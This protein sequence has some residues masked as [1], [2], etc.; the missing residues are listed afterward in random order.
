[1]KRGIAYILSGTAYLAGIGLTL[2]SA[3]LITMASAQPPLL[4][5][6][7]AI[8]GV[9]FFGITRSVARYF[10]RLTSHRTVF[11]KLSAL[12]VHLFESLN[13]NSFALVRDVGEG[14]LVKRIVD[15]V[16]RVEEYELRITLPHIAALISTCGGVAL[17]AWILPVSLL[18]TLP[19]TLFL[20]FFLPIFVKRRC[21]SLA[22][23]VELLEND[24]SSLIREATYGMAEARFYGYL[25]ERLSR[26]RI[27]EEKLRLAER[28]LLRTNRKFATTF[29]LVTGFTL[30]GLVTLA[31]QNSLTIPPVKVAM[32]VFLPL[33]IFEATSMWYPNLFVAGK[34]L[35]AKREVNQTLTP[36][37]HVQVKKT[38]I[39]EPLRQ[40]HVINA[41]V[42]WPGQ[43]HF[44]EPISFSLSKNQILIIRGRSGSGKSTLAMALLGLLDYEGQILLNGVELREIDNAHIAG[45]IQ[46]SH[47]FNTS[48]RENLRIASPLASDEEIFIALHLVELDTLVA[49]MDDGLDTLIGGFGRPISGG[50]AKRLSL[51]RALLSPAQLLV[52]DEPTEH[53]DG[54]LASR[55]TERIVALG[56]MCVVITHSGWQ[57]QAPTIHLHR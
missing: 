8:V 36:V 48:L 51:A 40:L 10:E 29:I 41:R 31:Y 46:S 19:A 38:T 16:E 13:A 47:I 17:G 39:D 56:R 42:R 37:E 1:M 27:M 24:Y 53:L 49:E 21:E 54:E 26:I 45:A 44:M 52:L 4:T 55:I 57:I 6:E 18:L 28:E 30:V 33:V 50:E 22:G 7:V 2:T 32:L 35:L 25:D 3:W 43:D 14:K 11:A 12:R 15:D 23:E 34:L 9:R 20:L 5:L